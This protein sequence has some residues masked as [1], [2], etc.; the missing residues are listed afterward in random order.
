MI[1]FLSFLYIYPNIF[2]LKF[3]YMKIRRCTYIRLQ[4]DYRVVRRE[5]PPG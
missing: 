2:S 3:P 4:E 1:W 5:K